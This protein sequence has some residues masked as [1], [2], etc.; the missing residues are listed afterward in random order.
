MEPIVYLD[1]SHIH[2][3]SLE[4]L[5]EGIRRLVDTMGPREP[6]LISYGFHLDEHA[7][8]MSVV[9]VHPNSASLERHMEIGRD[10]FRKLSEFITL[11]QIHVY[12]RISERA[13]G[14]LEQ[15]VKMLGGEGLL[16]SERFAGFD[17]LMPA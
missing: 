15:K 2:D 8:E 5:K 14:M 17:H 13:K 11:K 6:Q 4:A 16:V 3:G 9:A 12:G 7:G 1:F 10:E